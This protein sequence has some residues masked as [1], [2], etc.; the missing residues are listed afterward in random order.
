[1]DRRHKSNLLLGF[2][3]SLFFSLSLLL[4]QVVV[5]AQAPAT[6]K[7]KLSGKVVFA[8]NGKPAPDVRV[9]LTAEKGVG[10]QSVMTDESGA[11]SFVNL[12][13][14][15]YQL[16]VWSPGF[17]PDVEPEHSNRILLEEGEERRGIVIRLIKGGVITGRPLDEDDEPVSSVRVSAIAVIGGEMLE[18]GANTQP[19]GAYTDDRGIYRIFGIP[20]GRYRI[21]ANA[22]KSYFNRSTIGLIATYYP[23]AAFISQ[24]AEI[25]IAAGQVIEGLDFKL[26][27]RK[28]FTVSGLVSR[29][30]KSIPLANT[31]VIIPEKGSS[32]GSSRTYTTDGQGRY[33]FD[34]LPTGEYDIYAEPRRESDLLNEG[35][36]IVIE[37]TDLVNVDFEL[38]TGATLS[39]SIKMRDGKKPERMQDSRMYVL[40]YE[41]RYRSYYPYTMWPRMINLR[42]QL[43]YRRCSRR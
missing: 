40:P 2:H 3:H 20:P 30:D 24:A 14:G 26:L 32:R 23:G 27:N 38:T 28:G 1:M 34:G 22:S 36:T 8:G 12:K 11:F 21:V 18:G 9:R 4:I 7:G 29:K 13:S 15:N 10:Q 5:V 43:H 35:K 17:V 6:G 37:S 39:G 19:P 25:E 31:F 42:Q 16:N 33:R 41:T